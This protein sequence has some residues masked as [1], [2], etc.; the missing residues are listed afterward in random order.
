MRK[1]RTSAF[2]LLCIL[3]LA[4]SSTGLASPRGRGQATCCKMKH[5]CYQNM[6]CCKKA[7]HACCAG[8]HVADGC[9]CKK[10]SCPMPK[11]NAQF[12]PGQAK[13][14]AV[15]YDFVVQ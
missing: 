2:T 9:C 7:N 12:Q 8:K 3:T 4:A 1:I 14:I 10:D 6:R 11:T 13:Q 15:T 5:C